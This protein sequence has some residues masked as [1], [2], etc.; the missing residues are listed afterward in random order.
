M[1]TEGVGCGRICLAS[2]N[3]AVPKNHLLCKDLGD[4]SYTSR[5]IADHPPVNSIDAVKLAVLENPT[6]EPKITT[7]SCVQPEL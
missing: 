3:S 6:T 7:Q 5:V 1:A 4:I 2:F